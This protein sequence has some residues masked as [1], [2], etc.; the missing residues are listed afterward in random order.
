[1]S[2]CPNCRNELSAAGSGQLCLKCRAEF[3]SNDTY[4]PSDLRF[5]GI[6]A[7]VLTAAVLS[8]PGAFVGHLIGGVFDDA[9]RGCIIGVAVFALAGLVAGFRIGQAVVM[10]MD[11]AKRAQ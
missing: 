7:G 2:M 1:M 3:L 9:S 11:A 5:V 6:L 4:T 8:M 10:R